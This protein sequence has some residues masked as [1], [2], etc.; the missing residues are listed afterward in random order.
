ME[1]GPLPNAAPPDTRR[2]VADGPG[3]VFPCVA[4][5]LGP[6]FLGVALGDAVHHADDHLLGRELEVL[7]VDD[8]DAEGLGALEQVLL[9][10]HD[11]LEVAHVALRGA[12][13]TAMGPGDQMRVERLAILVGREQEDDVRPAPQPEGSK[14][15]GTRL[16]PSMAVFVPSRIERSIAARTPTEIVRDCSRKPSTTGS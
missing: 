10:A 16:T 14:R 7:H 6:T 8:G 4:G 15:P 2:T 12:G 3:P 9:D 13:A 5:G 1:R 11:L